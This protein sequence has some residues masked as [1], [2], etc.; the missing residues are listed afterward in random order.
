M[1]H[2][3][4]RGSPN[5]PLE[6]KSGINAETYSNAHAKCKVEVGRLYLYHTPFL[7]DGAIL[8]VYFRYN[9]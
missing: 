6:P 8:S 7:V 9:S 3:R 4:V 2:R 5:Y 1:I